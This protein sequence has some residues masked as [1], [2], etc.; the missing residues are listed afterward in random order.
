AWCGHSPTRAESGVRLVAPL[1]RFWLNTGSLELGR[2]ITREALER[3][4]AQE[5]TLVRA[6]AL[7]ALSNLEF[8]LSRHA[9]SLL[10]AEAMLASARDQ[11]DTPAICDGLHAAAHAR[12]GVGDVAGARAIYQEFVALA[13]AS[14]DLGRLALALGSLA[15]LLRF[16]G[17]VQEAEPVY[18]ESLELWR[19]M[20]DPQN[21]VIIRFN[22]AAVAIQRGAL[23]RARTLLAEAG[24]IVSVLNARQAGGLMDFVGAWRA[25]HEQ[26]HGAARMFGAA[27]AEY[28]RIGAPEREPVDEKFIRPRIDRTRAALG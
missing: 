9:E 20:G 23:D 14:A 24:G 10:H 5:R 21:V 8:F 1:R 11:G 16:E 28:Q 18:E 3:P 12:L 27:E 15:E 26:W 19:T 6:K 13:R 2:R 17:D 25:G 7:Y 4:G 22:L